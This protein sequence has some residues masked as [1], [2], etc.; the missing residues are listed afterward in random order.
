MVSVIIP[1]YNKEEY[2]RRAVDSALGQTFQDFE[3]IVVNDGSTDNGPVVVRQYD[4]PRLRVI[5]QENQGVSA[6]RNR[7]IAEAKGELIAFLDADDEWLP[8][9]LAVSVEAIESLGLHWSLTG[10]LGL[11]D[12]DHSP[13]CGHP[14]QAKGGAER[15]HFFHLCC[16]G[17][18]CP[19]GSIVLRRCVFREIG[20]FNEGITHGE[21]VEMW[22]RVGLHY[23][24]VA[25]NPAVLMIYHLSADGRAT[26]R[27]RT[28][29]KLL[30]FWQAVTALDDSACD[31]ETIQA[32]RVVRNRF[33]N[34]AIRF[35]LL[36]DCRKTAAYLMQ[37][38]QLRLSYLNKILGMSP[39]WSSHVLLTSFYRFR[40]LARRAARPA[41]VCR[42]PIR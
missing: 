36:A 9:F 23:P 22:W 40:D 30:N 14:S 16:R 20:S 21:D 42:T 34:K 4:D 27:P 10:S 13:V 29:E 2:I 33:A 12:G 38:R 17:F 3:L 39:Y 8:D 28:D 24:Y 15:G 18:L 26:N 19:I 25:Y 37:S 41:S 32:F 7:G 31:P 35:Y 1:L 5:D 11:R 6:A